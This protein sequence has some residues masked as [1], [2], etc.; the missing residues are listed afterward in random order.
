MAMLQRVLDEIADLRTELRLSRPA[1]TDVYCPRET[2][3]TLK[4][5]RHAL[6]VY[7]QDG[8][9]LPD[10]HVLCPGGVPL[11]S[12]LKSR[13]DEAKDRDSFTH[14]LPEDRHFVA[15]YKGYER[16]RT[17]VTSHNVWRREAVFGPPG[18]AREQQGAPASRPTVAAPDESGS[19]G[20]NGTA[21]TSAPDRNDAIT[22]TI[23]WARERWGDHLTAANVLRAAGSG[24]WD[25]VLERHGGDWRAVARSIRQ[26]LQDQTS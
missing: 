12:S 17:G 7:S 5:R 23:A 4:Q 11:Q 9:E 21:A 24:T 14:P 19:N 10:D 22:R 3:G 18:P 20:V 25:E 15:I 6:H 1:E 8:E 13:D 26:S 16:N 2:V